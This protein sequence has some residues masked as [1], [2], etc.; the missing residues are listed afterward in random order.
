MKTNFIL[1]ITEQSKQNMVCFLWTYAKIKLFHY[2]KLSE[3]LPTPK[4]PIMC[5]LVVLVVNTKDSNLENTYGIAIIYC[6]EK[7]I[8][9]T[10][11]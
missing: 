6:F 11:Y 1:C 10:L 2:K 3:F 5:T 8:A 9:K 4:K 7:G